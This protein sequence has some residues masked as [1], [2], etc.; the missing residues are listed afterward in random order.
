MANLYTNLSGCTHHLLPLKLIVAFW[1]T[2]FMVAS[3][4]QCLSSKLFIYWIIF[5][6]LLDLHTMLVSLQI[7]SDEK[8]LRK[9][10]CLVIRNIHAIRYIFTCEIIVIIISIA[11][12]VLLFTDPGSFL[13]LRLL[14]THIIIFFFNLFSSKHKQNT[15]FT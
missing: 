13:Q 8:E 9:E 2:K 10:I 4:Q 3:N 7:S 11:N 12:Y 14:Y 6:V 1:V 5:Y 15:T